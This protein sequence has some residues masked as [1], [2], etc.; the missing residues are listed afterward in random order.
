VRSITISLDE[1]VHI[2]THSPLIVQSIFFQFQNEV[3]CRFASWIAPCQPL[4]LVQ[5]CRTPL[6][7]QPVW[8]VSTSSL[9]SKMDFSL[10]M[11]IFYFQMHFLYYYWNLIRQYREE[12]RSD[13]LP[14]V[15]RLCNWTTMQSGWVWHWPLPVN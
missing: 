15:I 2:I 13:M 8:S 4:I 3:L 5:L 6:Q 9:D 11:Y 10:M 14:N 1:N 12:T 7:P